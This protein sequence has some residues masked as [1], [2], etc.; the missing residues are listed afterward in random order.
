MYVTR[1]EYA[2]YDEADDVFSC[3]YSTAR[4]DDD[5]QVDCVHRTATSPLFSASQFLSCTYYLYHK[6]HRCSVSLLPYTISISFSVFI[7]FIATIMYCCFVM[8]SFSVLRG[9]TLVH[10]IFVLI[11][12]H[13]IIKLC[14]YSRRLKRFNV[15]DGLL[16]H[17]NINNTHHIKV[18]LRKEWK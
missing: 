5:D 12:S 6:H 13:C 2:V 18:D 10:H 7:I 17:Q 15:G 4:N 1:M 3:N 9:C 16:T 8:T 14:F 11:I